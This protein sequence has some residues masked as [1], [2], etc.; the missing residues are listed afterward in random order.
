MPQASPSPSGSRSDVVLER[1]VRGASGTI[2]VGARSS[3]MGWPAGAGRV[4]GRTGDSVWVCPSA[5]DAV[6]ASAPGGGANRLGGR[7]VVALAPCLALGAAGSGNS[8]SHCRLP[9]SAA[10]AGLD[11]VDSGPPQPGSG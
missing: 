2:G 11:S 10:V 1:S 8:S 6:D 4:L 9:D 7:R 3:S 5:V